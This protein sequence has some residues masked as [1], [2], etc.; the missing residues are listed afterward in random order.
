[1]EA[2]SRSSVKGEVGTSKQ[3]QK[4]KAAAAGNPKH[5]VE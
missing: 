4:F 2:K 1:M 3:F 5:M